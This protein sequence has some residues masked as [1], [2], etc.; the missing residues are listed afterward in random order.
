MRP[1]VY[2]M[3]PP[4]PPLPPGELFE[5]GS[6]IF[7]ISAERG[8]SIKGGGGGIQG[9]T[10]LLI[11]ARLQNCFFFEMR[12]FCS[13]RLLGDVCGQSWMADFLWPLFHFSNA[14]VVFL[15]LTTLPVQMAILTGSE[16]EAVDVS[17]WSLFW[18]VEAQWVIC[19]TRRL[20]ACGLWFSCP[21]GTLYV[22][23]V[24]IDHNSHEIT[25]Q[26]SHSMQ[27]SWLASQNGFHWILD[28]MT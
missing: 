22:G 9:N 3:S 7:N 15:R 8:E 13:P 17:R 12:A 1:I 23:H 28:T 5:G 16:R 21:H 10:L 24:W 20:F 4:P 25:T 14:F 18:K 19:R 2:T 26:L 11:L 6:Y 27:K